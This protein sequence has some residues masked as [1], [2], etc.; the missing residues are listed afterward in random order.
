MKLHHR[1]SGSH[2][3]HLGSLRQLVVTILGVHAAHF[4]HLHHTYIHKHIHTQTQ[5]SMESNHTREWWREND[6]AANLLER[7]SGW[8][9]VF[10]EVCLQLLLG[11]GHRVHGVTAC[12][13]SEVPEHNGIQLRNCIPQQKSLTN[14]HSINSMK[15]LFGRGSCLYCPSACSVTAGNTCQHK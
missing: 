14:S 4:P 8:G 7:R 13:Q 15:L 10:L 3:S 9:L 1:L 6:L 2:D 11:L 5:F 12:G